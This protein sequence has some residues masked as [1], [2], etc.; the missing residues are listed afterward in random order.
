MCL[1]R[2]RESERAR[3]HER[4]R[5]TDRERERPDEARDFPVADNEKEKAQEGHERQHLFFFSPIF[6][7]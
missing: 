7:R 6:F 2:G 5:E 3:T 1:E 4:E